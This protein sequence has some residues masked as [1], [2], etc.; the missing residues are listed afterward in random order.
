MQN[1]AVAVILNEQKQILAVSRKYDH[2]DFGLPGGKQEGEEDIWECLSR[3]VLEET[4]LVVKDLAK[5][6]DTRRGHDPDTYVWCFFAKVGNSLIS[7][8]EDH[9]VKWMEPQDFISQGSFKEYNSAIIGTYFNNL[10]NK[11][12]ISIFN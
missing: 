3:E 10:L 9:V 11:S 6:I 1:V 12:S 4:G 8:P 5:L 2:N 7:T